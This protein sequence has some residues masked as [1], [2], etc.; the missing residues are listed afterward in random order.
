[1]SKLEVKVERI[2]EVCPHENADRLEI[3]TF[4]NLGWQCVGQKGVYTTGDLVVYFPIDSILPIEIET[5]IFGPDSKIKL[6]KSRVRTIK[7]RGVVSQGLVC[8]LETL[9]L[10]GI[11]LGTDLTK[12][13]GVTKYEPP[14]KGSPQ[15]QGKKSTK[16]RPNPNFR[17]YTSIENYKKYPNVFSNDEIVYVEEKLH[18]TNFGASWALRHTNNILVKLLMR[19]GIVNKWEF[20]F[21]SHNVQLQNK[22]LNKT[23][24]KKNVYAEAVRK[25]NI[26][27]IL[28]KGYSIYGEIIGSGIQK[29]YN[30]GCGEGERKL[31][32]FDV[33]V[34]N[35]Y[36]DAPDR[37]K[38]V[39]DIGL[40]QPPLLYKGIFDIH[41]IKELTKGNSVL[42]P[43][44]KVREGVVIKPIK[45]RIGHMG[46]TVLKLI[47]DDYLL[48]KNNT[49]FH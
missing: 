26:K 2:N 30:Y 22:L 27:N 15:V 21:R 19:I 20:C 44:Q 35:K 33:M 28:P 24:Y 7:L 10:Q 23:Y 29:G 41:H 49:E 5:K 48:N 43:T 37:R 3:L 25:Y 11:K 42:E 38:W 18:G 16:K 12:Q 13:L 39:S 4:D 9:G 47:S 45:E 17:K 40:D 34:N 46:R 36:I 14:I 32:V 8:P 1:M 6:E 31:Y